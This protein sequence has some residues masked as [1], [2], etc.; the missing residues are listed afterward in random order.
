V[1]ATNPDAD[2]S[3]LRDALGRVVA[4]T[5]DGREVVSRYDLL[6]RRVWRRTPSGAET[7]WEYGADDRPL[8][9]HA[10]NQLVTF[11]YDLAGQEVA[12]R[13]GT[14]TLLTQSWDR[15][16]RL[17]AQT[18]TAEA[19][20]LQQRMF[21][22]RADSTLQSVEDLLAGPRR[23]GL[24]AG[25]R[26]TT[27]EVASR[28]EER[29]EYALSGAPAGPDRSYSGTLVRRVG[30]VR[31]EYDA[32]GRV[33]LRQRSTLSS[34]PRT[35][36]YEWNDENRLT[37]L[38]TPDRT[39]WRYRYDAFGRRVAKEGST[40]MVRSRSRPRRPVRSLGTGAPMAC[41]R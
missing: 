38:T 30:P 18:L 9:L 23:Y 11:D 31:Y 21:D 8:A 22:Y 35:W 2:V 41:G 26:I 15:S 34:G 5:I 32:A 37:A 4:E 36:R 19:E 16:H 40:P 14:G 29:Y 24:D 27:V 10:D 7:R 25:N 20:R 1:R 3:L 6:G 17:T 13:V 28:P 39:R 33:T 12:R